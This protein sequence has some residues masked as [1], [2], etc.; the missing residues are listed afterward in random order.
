[1]GDCKQGI[2]TN[3]GNSRGKYCTSYLR[4]SFLSAIL[5]IALLTIKPTGSRMFTL[6]IEQQVEVG[7]YR[8]E[9]PHH[10]N[11]YAHPE[12]NTAGK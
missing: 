3:T 8:Q 11:Q 1:M 12:H 4:A 9:C 2:L 7:V 10:A 6:Y 5:E